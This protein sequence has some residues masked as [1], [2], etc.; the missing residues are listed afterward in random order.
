MQVHRYSVSITVLILIILAIFGV[1]M[2]LLY[3]EN[4]HPLQ[5]ESR[6][7]P[8][9]DL[10]P[11]ENTG[12]GHTRILSALDLT[13]TPAQTQS[14]LSF[15]LLMPVGLLITALAR[16]LIGM[17]TIGTFTPTLLALSQARS[18]WRIGVVI[19]AVTFGLGSLCRMVLAKLRLS[20]VPRR[21]AKE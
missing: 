6:V 20:T 8:E 11:A 19:F 17:R 4:E 13:R 10:R 14:A 16:S 3:Y 2:R 5:M 12:S 15:L 21:G 9:E 18:D 1:S 7:L